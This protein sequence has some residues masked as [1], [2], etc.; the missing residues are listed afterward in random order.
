MLVHGFD[1]RLQGFHEQGT[2][3]SRQRSFY[4]ERAVFVIGVAHAP[5]RLL[6]RF[7]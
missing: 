4:D 2:R 6:A 5:S 3:F 7:A 1:G